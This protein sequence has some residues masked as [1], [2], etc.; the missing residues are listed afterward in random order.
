PAEREAHWAE[1]VRASG[2][3]AEGVAAFLERRAPAF[4]WRP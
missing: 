4:P 1:Q 2:E 3:T